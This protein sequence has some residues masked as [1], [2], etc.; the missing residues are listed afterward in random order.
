MDEQKRLMIRRAR[1]SDFIE[2]LEASGSE[3]GPAFMISSEWSDEWGLFTSYMMD[4]YRV[5][6]RYLYDQFPV[7]SSIVN[8]HMLQKKKEDQKFTLSNLK[9]C[10]HFKCS[11]DVIPSSEGKVKTPTQRRLVTQGNT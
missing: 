7:P 10:K 3:N 11:M 8:D 6:N 2:A 5:V 9:P 4:D 1:E